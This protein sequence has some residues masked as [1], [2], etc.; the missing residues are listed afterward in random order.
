MPAR[1]C[2][3][4]AAFMQGG[5]FG[6]HVR[7]MR[8]RYA[9]RQAALLEAARTQLGGLL[10]LSADPAGLH[11]IAGLSPALARQVNDREIESIAA[12]A[13]VV[14]VA[15]SRLRPSAGAAGPA[16]RLCGFRRSRSTGGAAAC[17]AAAPGAGHGTA[18]SNTVVQSVKRLG[19]S[20]F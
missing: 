7:Q 2:S 18:R 19:A 20:R 17:R 16:A 15:L 9:A 8:R 6:S 11:L 12:A 14:T 5:Y 13:D 3:R 4:L 1:F 10:E